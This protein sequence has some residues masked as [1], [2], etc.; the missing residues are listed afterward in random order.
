ML[1]DEEGHRI[2]GACPPEQTMTLQLIHSFSYAMPARM[3]V[4]SRAM[5]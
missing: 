2:I 1:A 3:A 5:R 4:N